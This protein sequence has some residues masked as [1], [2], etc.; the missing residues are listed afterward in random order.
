MAEIE[1]G[2]VQEKGPEAGLI[3]TRPKL[4]VGTVSQP[5]G[6]DWVGKTRSGVQDSRISRVS[7]GY[8][9]DSQAVLESHGFGMR[10]A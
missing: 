2:G 7:C 9:F 10:A 4:S 8:L 5:C 6:I 3:S 1:A